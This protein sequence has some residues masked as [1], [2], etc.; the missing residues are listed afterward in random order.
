[1]SQE[2]CRLLESDDPGVQCAAAVVL[3]ELKPKDAEVR[4]A[5]EGALK[6]GSESVRVAALGALEKLGIEKSVPK[7]VPLLAASGGLRHRA[8][9]ILLKGGA[10]SEKLLRDRL[11]SAPATLKRGIIDVL[12]QLGGT[13][14]VG[15]LLDSMLDGEFQVVRQASDSLIGQVRE[16]SDKDRAALAKKLVA[17]LKKPKVKKSPEAT[18]GGI[19]VLGYLAIPSTVPM[20]LQYV[21]AKQPA[22]VRTHAL[23]SMSHIE[24]DA[25]AKS[26]AAKVLPLLED[27]EPGVSERALKLLS[28]VPTPMEATDRLVRLA[29]AGNP[30][31]VRTYAA[32]AL[33]QV[34]TEKAA[35]ALIEALFSN[36]PQLSGIAAGALKSNPKFSGALVKALRKEKDVQRSWRLAN[37]LRTYGKKL[38]KTVLRQFLQSC[39]TLIRRKEPALQVYFEILRSIDPDLL[40]EGL[41]KEGR[42]LMRRKKIED[43][44]RYLRL[45]D[46]DDLASDESTFT[47][48]VCRLATLRKDLSQAPRDRSHALALFSRLAR[49]GSFPLVQRLQK[50]TLI[51]KAEG[52]LYLGFCL[53]EKVGVERDAGGKVLK[54]VAKRYAKKPEGKA[55]KQK[56]S[57]QGL[58]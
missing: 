45:L 46:R 58:S 54:F 14:T 43:A 6:A 13:E 8:S 40:R 30:T 27:K 38:G 2:I 32:R 57:T 41:L 3:G 23:N 21:G 56:L 50:E 7:L 33:G 19:K 12:G 11:K 20:L 37:L 49:G 10:K 36:D 39:I 24:V 4:R 17:F 55:A 28:R 35:G 26:V 53:T 42:A 48:A 29:G 22:V 16:M 31:A 25:H 44:E 51:L 34:G 52:L 9:E 15:T 47:L 18:V 5:L 1:M